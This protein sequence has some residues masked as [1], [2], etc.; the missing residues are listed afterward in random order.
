MTPRT[1]STAPAASTSIFAID[2]GKDWAWAHILNGILLAVGLRKL[3]SVLP[4]I[5]RL[6][7]EKPHT[8]QSKASKKDIITLAIRAGEVGGVVAHLTGIKP[9]YIEPVRWKGSVPKK[10]TNER[11]LAKLTPEELLVLGAKHN[12]NVL[13]AIGIALYIVGR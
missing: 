9:E 3:P 11:T 4:A 7:V 2:S 10:V 8:G 1:T 5:T 6:V 12:H 13:D